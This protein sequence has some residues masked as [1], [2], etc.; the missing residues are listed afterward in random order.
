MAFSAWLMWWSLGG[1]IWKSML[2]DLEKTLEGLG[3]IVVN[4]EVRKLEAAV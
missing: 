1:H 4:A 2:M 3:A